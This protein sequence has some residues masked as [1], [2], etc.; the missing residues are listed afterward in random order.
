MKR[1]LRREV[2]AINP[3]LKKQERSLI[4]NLTLQLKELEKEQIKP[5]ASRRKDII[6]IR[7]G[8]KET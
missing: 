5:K 1:V 3:Y 4:N 8:I 7:A 2:I 6:N